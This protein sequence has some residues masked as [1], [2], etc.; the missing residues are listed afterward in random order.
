M[1]RRPLQ[2]A[3]AAIALLIPG[4]VA[5]QAKPPRPHRSG[6]FAEVATGP[7]NA[8]VGCSGCE[9]VTRNA[10]A[11]STIRIGFPLSD[12]VLISLEAFSFAD[13]GF[14]FANSSDEARTESGLTSVS[15]L[16]Y[17]G[18]SG[19]FLKGGSGVAASE[20]TVKR[21]GESDLTVQGTGIG[22]NVGIGYD[23]TL[24]RRFA[25]TTNA[26]IHVAAI[27]DVLLPSGNVDDVIATIYSLNVGLTLR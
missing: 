1:T 7:A 6:F 25:L 19:F 22:L 3:L 21:D 4:L 9:E 16:W 18:R 13:E 23:L 5:A 26:A 27:G 10:G 17:P 11:S 8:R 12:H 20:F 14:A 2:G 24:S 15:L